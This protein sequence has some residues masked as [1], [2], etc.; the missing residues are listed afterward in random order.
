MPAHRASERLARDDVGEQGRDGGSF[1][2]N[3]GEYAFLEDSRYM[4]QQKNASAA[5]GVSAQWFSR[6]A[7]ARKRWQ[8]SE[9]NSAQSGSTSAPARRL[10]PLVALA[11][12]AVLWRRAAA[13]GE[14]T[15]LDDHDER[16]W[17]RLGVHRR[18]DDRFDASAE[19]PPG[20]ALGSRDRERTGARREQRVGV[21][22]D[23]FLDV[24]LR[25]R[26]RRLAN[27][28]AKA[29]RHEAR[30]LV[31]DVA[32]RERRHRAGD[33]HDR[34]RP[35]RHGGNGRALAGCVCQSRGG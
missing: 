25:L 7:G 3:F 26:G 10:D 13:V 19:T 33:E 32:S 9:T 28:L 21:G 30:D 5:I 6:N 18:G 11:L 22:A 16:D 2:R 14:L 24:G 27:G 20:D 31:G 17:L 23:E 4:S 35:R 12:T 29:L 1:N 34:E 8:R 15:V